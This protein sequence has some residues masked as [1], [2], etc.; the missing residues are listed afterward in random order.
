[1]QIQNKGLDSIT[2][3]RDMD[4]L[5]TKKNSCEFDLD[6]YARASIRVKILYDYIYVYK[7]EG[8]EMEYSKCI[9]N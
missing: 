5:I 8:D 9:T 7:K 2:K 1:M 4:D 3:S 6:R